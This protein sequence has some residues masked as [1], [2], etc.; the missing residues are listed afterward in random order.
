MSCTEFMDRNK[1]RNIVMHF[2][3]IFVQRYR[4][5]N[6]IFS[7]SLQ[8]KIHKTLH[9]PFFVF[10]LSKRKT[11]FRKKGFKHFSDK[12]VDCLLLRATFFK[13]FWCANYICFLCLVPNMHFKYL[14]LKYLFDL[15]G[16][17]CK[18]ILCYWSVLFIA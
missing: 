11:P 10:P 6:C 18:I 2:E 17:L 15:I 8:R 12:N 7:A 16:Q 4:E 1:Y 3:S 14:M 13:S 9:A 5:T